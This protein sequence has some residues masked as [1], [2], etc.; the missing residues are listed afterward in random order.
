LTQCKVLADTALQAQSQRLIPIY[1]KDLNKLSSGTK[2]IFEQIY[3][4]P[5]GCLIARSVHVNSVEVLYCN[6][7]N[8]SDADVEFK[9]DHIIGTLSE[10]EIVVQNFDKAIS[11][12]KRLDV[13]KLVHSSGKTCSSIPVWLNNISEKLIT[14]D[15]IIQH[16]MRTKIK[17]LRFG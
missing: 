11:N 9:K 15:D 13:S 14:S 16:S 2:L 1:S 6:V 8:S 3:P 4:Y 12:Y 17:T 5:D 10:A 7:I